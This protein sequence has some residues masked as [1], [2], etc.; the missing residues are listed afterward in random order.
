MEWTKEWKSLTVIVAAF[1]V[2]FYLPVGKPRFDNAVMESLQLV[3]WY[4]QEHVLLCL[5]P[6]FFVAGAI[7]VFVSQ[8]SVMRYLGAKANKVLAYGV[9]SVS[10]TILAVCS[11]TVLPLFAGIY[12]MGAG[13]GP[14]TAFLYSGPAINVLAIFLTARIL[15][16]EMGMARAVGAVVFSVIVGLLMHLIYRKEET[17]RVEA[18][19]AEPDPPA[20]RPLWQTVLYFASMIAVLVFANWG[21]SAEPVGVW[22]TVYEIKW[23]LTGLSALALGLMLIAWFSVA[24]WKIA[25][26]AIPVA[27]LS[28]L[29]REYPLIPFAAGFVGL[30][31]IT[32]TDDGE[33]G[34]WFEQT[35][36]FAKQILPLL[37]FGVLIA[38]LLLGRPGQE[39]IIPSEWISRS[40]GGNSLWANLFASVA[41]AFMY[42]ATL[43]EI[44]I[45]Q[46]LLGS[47][48]GKGPALALL[49]A[50]PAL[51]LPS[52]LVLRSIMGLRKT[53]VFVTITVV[54]ATITGMIYGAVWG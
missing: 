44:P 35:W 18:Q 22:N 2:S 40:V 33:M 3:K 30:S 25:A 17:A 4:A 15:G 54:M 34:S 10:G 11:C 28:L 16:L 51:S 24:W 48:M 8:A 6:A 26:T 47:G 42:F 5:I 19:M 49:L 43:T 29:F 53:V 52:M 1:L 7:G 9:A 21:K 45:L 50:G 39:G 38:G 36:G 32:S 20:T 37:L 14:A 13:L 46:G 41:G 27:I 31:I 23:Y 12:R